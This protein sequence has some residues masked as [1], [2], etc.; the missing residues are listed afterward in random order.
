MWALTQKQTLWG[1]DALEHGDLRLLEDGS[2]SGSA[3]GSD[4]V[5]FETVSEGQGGKR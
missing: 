4:G 3:L 2:E 5:A 1:G